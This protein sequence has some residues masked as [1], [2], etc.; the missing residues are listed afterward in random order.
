M[1][2]MSRLKYFVPSS[3]LFSTATKPYSE[4][5]TPPQKSF[6]GHLNL[7]VDKQFLYDGVEVFRDYRT[8]YGEIVKLVFPVI[9]DIV[10]VFNPDDI[11]TTVTNDGKYP[12]TPFIDALALQRRS[13]LK[14]FYP[15]ESKL[16]SKI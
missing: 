3:K 6:L 9:E 5:P 8:K 1:V 10:I 12:N 11:K 7:L 2:Y 13:M 15:K 14:Q 4:I 16:V